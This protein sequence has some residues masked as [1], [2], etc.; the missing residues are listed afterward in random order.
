MELSLVNYQAWEK[1]HLGIEGFT[2][3]VGPS[4][5]GKSSFGRAVRSALRNELL[6]GHIR[7]GSTGAEVSLKFNDLDL[8][9]T[10]GAKAKDSTV[11]YVGD[12]KFEKLGGD[13]PQAVKDQS[14]GPVQVN[15]VSIDPIFAGQFDGQFMVGASPSELNAILNAF[16]STERLDRG[17]KVLAQRVAD[18][19]AQAK[20]LT[21]QVSALEEQEQ[22]LADQISSVE[23][24]L[25]AIEKLHA[26]V[27]ML[28]KAVDAV[29]A[30]IL[31]RESHA[32][33]ERQLG[34][35]EA[36]DTQLQA[37][38]KVYKALVRTKTIHDATT[39]AQKAVFQV[40]H[41]Q[42]VEK[43]APGAVATGAALQALARLMAAQTILAANAGLQAA[44]SAV[45]DTLKPALRYYKA[46]VRVRAALENDSTQVK[47]LAEQIHTLDTSQP[48]RILQA[49][50]ILKKLQATVEAVLANQAAQTDLQNQQA[51]AAQEVAEAEAQL[52]A[53]RK[54][55]VV[56]P[57][58]HH[59]FTP[60]HAH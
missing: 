40:A 33:V 24:P 45:E 21:P 25:Q 10:R 19:N 22:A 37:T 7:L 43:A 28:T 11:Y 48:D 59:E 55:A 13:I 51:L 49:G 31:A 46:L 5:L 56:C 29:K 4:S 44:V 27:L 32:T 57:K 14:F 41:I 3:V 6:P 26:Q 36:L 12:Q 42:A 60:P 50:I 20:A 54:T 15:G 30:L 16:A 9:V 52:E 23:E 58:C 35:V 1:A 18:I 34:A 17:R 47:A 38:L 39:L 8:R 2:A 53:A